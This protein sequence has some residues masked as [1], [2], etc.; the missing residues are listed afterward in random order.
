LLFVHKVLK[1]AIKFML[2]EKPVAYH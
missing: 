1:N 2:T